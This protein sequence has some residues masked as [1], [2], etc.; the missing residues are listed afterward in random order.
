MAGR[1]R[2]A[3]AAAG[4]LAASA[5]ASPAEGNGRDEGED[6]TGGE[7]MDTQTADLAQLKRDAMDKIIF[8]ATPREW[9][10]Q[11]GPWVLERGEGAL[12]YDADGR[13][14]LDALSGGVFAVLAGYGRE[15]IAR[16]MYEQARRLPYT[17]PYGTT[18]AVTVELARKL[19]ELTPGDLGAVVLLQ[20]RL[21]GGRGGD[22][23]RSS[24]SRGERRGPPLQGRLPAAR[25]SRLDRRRAVG[26]RLEPGVRRLPAQRR[27][28]S[29]LL[30]GSRAPCRPT[31]TAASWG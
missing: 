11:R 9:L 7:V 15:E 6:S 19:A 12:L 16:A 4:A 5:G 8:H 18:S 27:P 1:R 25:L 26:D 2:G 22:Q 30:R 13:E 29:S 28:V 3:L 20:Q 21:R 14:Y 17:S 24:I 10:R 23:A 31:A